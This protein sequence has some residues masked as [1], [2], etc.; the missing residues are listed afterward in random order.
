MPA[1]LASLLAA[2]ALLV[3]PRAS[4]LSAG[5]GAAKLKKGGSGELGLEQ[6]TAYQEQRGDSRYHIAWLISGQVSRFIY[7]DGT[8]LLSDHLSGFV[9]CQSRANCGATLDVHIA[10]ANTHTHKHSHQSVH[11]AQIPAALLRGRSI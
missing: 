9:G 10:L 7:K 2:W 11:R 4:G 5:G 3:L 1:A 8:S 6:A